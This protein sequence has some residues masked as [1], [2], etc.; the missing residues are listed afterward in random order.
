MKDEQKRVI[1]WGV[2]ILIVILAVI[3]L[4]Q[5]SSGNSASTASKKSV[6]FEIKKDEWILGPKNASTTIVEYFDMQCP[7][8][9]SFHPAMK[10]LH[11]EFPEKLRIV[12][13]HFPLSQIHQNA[14]IAAQAL[15]AAGL[16]GKFFEMQD[17]LFENQRSWSKM[18][19]PKSKFVEYAKKIGLNQKKF[20]SD[21]TSQKVKN[22]VKKDLSSARKY[23]INSTPTLFLNGTEIRP[24]SYKS[25]RSSVESQINSQ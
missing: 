20:E 19:N 15:E 16:Q 8:C 11:Q 12:F 7:A 4:G 14:M 24:R 5:L 9:K 22:K 3:G 1:Y 2:G 13:R 25:L 21:L 6:D 18:K 23:N 17:K 10:K